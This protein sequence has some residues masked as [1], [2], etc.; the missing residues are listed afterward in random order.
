MLTLLEIACKLIGL[1]EW[2][3]SWKGARD[4]RKQQQAVAD[5]PTTREELDARL[6][7]H[8]F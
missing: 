5:A 2:F 8:Q 6:K 7:D 3:K 1:A 4:M